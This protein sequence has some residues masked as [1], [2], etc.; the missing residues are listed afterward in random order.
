MFK[1]TIVLIALCVSAIPCR[2]Q[3]GYEFEVYSTNIAPPGEAELETHINFVPSGARFVDEAGGRA[4]HRAF[5]ASV[6]IGTSLTS[7]LE[8]SIYTVGYARNGAGIQ[9][10]GNRARM[11]AV[12]PGSRLP[13]RVGLSQEVGYAQPGFAENRWAYEVTPI[14]EQRFGRQ[15]LVLNSAFERGLGGGGHEW[16]F[17]PRA[18]LTRS[19]GDEEAVGLEYYSVLGPVTSFDA[20]SHQIHQIFATGSAELA[21]GWKSVLGVGRGLTRNSDRWVIVTRFE[22]EL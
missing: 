15:S 10:V 18:A 11:T 21:S 13:F 19:F 17:E 8:A 22:V 20:R 2:A 16:E 7:W 12:V 9:Y 1:T 3:G 4:T 14:V 5:R 6:E